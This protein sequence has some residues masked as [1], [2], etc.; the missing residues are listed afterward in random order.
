MK[1]LVI[2]FIGGGAGSMA[3]YGIALL[4][5]KLGL[6]H[7]PVATL[8]SNVF[9]CLIVA[10]ALYYLS[11]QMIL[12][13]ALRLL[14]ITGFCGGFSTFSAFSYETIQLLRDKHVYLALLNVF[15]NIA[16]CFTLLFSVLRNT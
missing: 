4:I 15:L 8:L 5:R 9:S 1:N 14:L 11:E 7:F 12:Q 6:D 10:I 2:V 3:R 16:I 13:P